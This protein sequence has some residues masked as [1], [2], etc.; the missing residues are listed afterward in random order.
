MEIIKSILRFVQLLW[1]I[2]ITALI[3]NVIASNHYGHESSINYSLFA[4]CMAWLALIFGLA[5]S[6]TGGSFSDGIFGYV[7]LALDALA[8]LF[9]FIAGIVLAAKLKAVDCGGDLSR[10]HSSWIGF[11]SSNDE[12][13]CRE[14]QASTAFF[15]F[16]AATLAVSL[17]MS[18]MGG[19]GRRIGGSSGGSS[20]PHMSQVRV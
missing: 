17:A 14:I 12:K 7:A 16:L 6:L 15:W 9:T 8:T 2:L 3:G 11:G 13:R 19:M 10:R 5:T 4:V 20:A 1:V 18:V